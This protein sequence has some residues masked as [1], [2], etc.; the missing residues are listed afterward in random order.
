MKY[1]G[2]EI[3][4]VVNGIITGISDIYCNPDPVELLEVASKIEEQRSHS[5]VARLGLSAR[6][7]GYIKR[8]LTELGEQLH[9]LLLDAESH[10]E[11]TGGRG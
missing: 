5:D 2:A 10:D 6:T 9:T 8:R 1:Q 4:T 3:V 7:S 11:S